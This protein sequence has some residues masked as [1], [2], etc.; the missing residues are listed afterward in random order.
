MRTVM[1]TL[2]LLLGLCLMMSC[3]ALAEEAGAVEQLG[4][5]EASVDEV[6]GMEDGLTAVPGTLDAAPAAPVSNGSAVAINKKNFPDQGFRYYLLY[7]IDKNGDGKLS[8]SEISKTR[9]I[10]LGIM[11]QVGSLKG[12]ERF[13]NLRKLEVSIGDMSSVDLSKLKNL[14]ELTLAGCDKLKKL[15]VSK[16]TK[17]KKLNCGSCALKSLDLSK[18]TRLT[19]L[20]CYGN[21]LTKLNLSKNTKLTE[22][23][24][25]WNNLTKLDLSRNTKL[26]TLV[27]D[28]NKLKSLSL[29]KNRQLDWLQAED[30]RI[31]NL[32]L[33]KLTR[34]EYA[35]VLQ[36]SLKTVKACVGTT[37][38]LSTSDD[39]S[40]TIT[41]CYSSAPSV[42][43]ISSR[44]EDTDIKCVSR[45]TATLYYRLNGRQHSI[46]VTVV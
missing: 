23:D 41:D 20:D 11:D 39:I 26:K 8:K 9:T 18:N 36:D 42:L 2:S 29:S 25:K 30:N 40:S 16:N 38:I 31:A 1:R 46:A 14:E 21:R 5:A 6:E 45:G 28:G 19:K 10:E 13:T 7:N 37:L 44:S 22:L 12:I 43:A 24:C 32:D 27:C 17:L 3:G 34:L 15:D 35:F 4:E 33:S